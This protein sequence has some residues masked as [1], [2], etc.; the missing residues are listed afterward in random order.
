MMVS[1]FSKNSIRLLLIFLVFH[2]ASLERVSG[3]E[4]SSY[5]HRQDPTYFSFDELKRLSDIPSPG[6]EL[7]HKL[8]I[9]FRTPTIDNTAYYNGSKPHVPENPELG[10]YLQLVSWNIE[11]S[12]N[13]KD[14]IIAFTS[15]SEYTKLMDEKKAPH[16]SKEY[17]ATLRQREKLAKADIIVLQ[18]MEIGVKRSGYIHAAEAL[19]KA[20][21]MNFTFAPQYL[22]VDPVQLGTEKI[23]YDSGTIDNEATEYYSVDPALYKGVF[24]SAVLS[25]YPIKSVEVFPLKYQAYDW[26]SNEKKKTTYLEHT[27]RF[28]TKIAFQ[29]EITREIKIGGRHFYRVDLDVP[30]LEEGTLTIINIHLEIKCLPRDRE[31]QMQEILSYVKRIKHPVIMVGDFNS[32]EEDLSPTSAKRALVRAAKNPT[33]WLS[34]SISYFTSYGLI[35]NSLRGTSNITKNLFDPFALN[36]PIVAPNKIKDLFTTIQDFT[37]NDGKTFDFRGDKD[38]SINMKNGILANSNQRGAKGFKTTFSVRRPIAKIIGIYRLDWVFVKSY[39]TDPFDKNQTYRF[40]PHYGETL[41]MINLSLKERISDH[42]P[43]TVSLPFNEP[44][45]EPKNNDTLLNRIISI[46]IDT[47]SYP[48]RK[49]QELLNKERATNEDAETISQ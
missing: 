17:A 26:F 34:A 30:H 6:S 7:D 5:I 23:T 31:K 28:G 49:T 4:Q 11:Q 45:I 37:F 14:A 44:N 35:V 46:P 48:V 33:N 40:A 12:R 18:E 19:A 29:N 32:A 47:V 3:D 16:D 9:F 1:L 20:L 8:N 41:D 27:R 22:E 36:I 25:H 38:R 24:G 10:T 43:N 2:G 13:M 21:K 42:H 15:E 39:I